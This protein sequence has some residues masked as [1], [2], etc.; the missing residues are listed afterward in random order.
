MSFYETDATLSVIRTSLGANKKCIYILRHRT[1]PQYWKDLN[2]TGWTDEMVG[3][4]TMINLYAKIPLDSIKGSLNHI[5]I[6][7]DG[8]TTGPFLNL[9]TRAPFLQGGGDNQFKMM[10]KNGFSFDCTMPSQGHGFMNME[11]GWWPYTEDYK[12]RDTCQIQ[13]CPKCSHPGIWNQPILDLE[14]NL[15]EDQGHGFPCAMLDSCK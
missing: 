14:D 4:K 7:H 12:A 2:E 3:M 10:E 13:P 11:N 1:P 9:G 15:M 6:T 8:S 5:R